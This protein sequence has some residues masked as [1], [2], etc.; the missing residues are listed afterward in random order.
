MFQVF[1]GTDE[2]SSRKAIRAKLGEE[3]PVRFDASSWDS[4]AVLSAV[5]GNSLFGK[6]SPVYFDGVLDNED[7]EKFLSSH[8]KEINGSSH[9]VYLREKSIPA[10]L[11]KKMEKAGVSLTEF[12]TVN[13]KPERFKIFDLADALGQRNKKELWVLYQKALKAGLNP[14]EVAGTLFWQLKAI[15]IE[16]GGGKLNPFVAGKARRYGGN[17]KKDE[18]SSF[19]YSLL[20][21]YHE[22]HR[23]GVPLELALEKFILSL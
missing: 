18:V 2:E 19:A 20:T 14:E 4:G 7:A 5:L 9:D 16:E 11:L 15:L 17:F 12:K 13:K 3:S 1:Y 22:A 6:P 8:I 10:V 21:S 23:G